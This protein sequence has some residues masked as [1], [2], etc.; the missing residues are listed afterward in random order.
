MRIRTACL[1]AAALCAACA[2]DPDRQT[3]AR[4]HDVEPDMSEVQVEHGLDQAVA[5]YRKFL[6]EAPESSLTPEAMR[7]LADLQIEKEYGLLG[8][9]EGIR[10]M[11]APE[12]SAAPA[13]S[14]TETR[15]APAAKPGHSESEA[16]FERRAAA[17]TSARPSQ[18]G[19]ALDLPG[20]KSAPPGPLEAIA[21]YDQILAKYPNYPHNDEVLYQK[22]RA[23]DELGRTE[24]AIVVMEQMIALYPQSRHMDEVQFRRAEYFFT[25]KKYRDAEAA[26]SAITAMG[27]S[28]EYYE[29]ALYK[30]GWTFYKQ[31]LHVEALHQYVTLLDYKVGTGYDFDTPH[32]EDT[33][34][35]IA[36][37][38]HVV[39]LCFSNLG[40]PESIEQYFGANG[41]KSFEDRIYGHLGEF[42]LEK[43]R[44][45]D[46]A[47][48][49]R[50]FV[51]LNPLH[52]SAP[53][54]SMRVIE[55]YE[56]GGFPKL[57]LESK[58]QFAASYGLDS[59]YWRHFD[60]AASPEVLRYLKT[61]LQ[62]LASHYHARFQDP[63]GDEDREKSFQ[64]AARWYR[65]YLASF[66]KEEES[67]SI[68]YR[69][70]DLLLEHRDF[71][72]AAREYE[73]TA[74]EYPPHERAAAAGYA[75]IYAHRE[76]Q[77]QVS[78][79]EQ[80]TV[81][82]DA[83]AST[84]R[85]VDAFPQH[86]HA[87]A[88]LGAAVD[89]LYELKDY[90]PA[91]ATG[92]KLIERYPDAD[93]AIRRTAWT[94]VA[95]ASFET[96]GYA[97]AEQAY[98]RVLELTPEGDASRQ[99]LSDNL[100]AAIYKQGEQANA[101]ADPRAAAGHFLR[102][103]EAAP[104]S[105][106]RPAAEYDAGA[107]LMKVEDWAKAAEVLEA[108]RQ[109]YPDHELRAD[110]TRQIAF[111]R[112]AQG[113][114]S[115]AGEE[116]ERVSTEAGDSELQREALLEAGDLYEKSGQS[117]RALAAWRSY[118]TRFPDPLETAVE[119]RWKIAERLAASH[120]DAAYRD[121]LGR[122]VA[123]DRAAGGQRTD[124][125]R[126]LAARSA[127]ALSERLYREFG[128][129]ALVQPFEQSLKRK[130]QRM[131]AAL[132]AFG[133]LVDYEVGEVTAA[134]TFYMAELYAD[135]GQ[136]LMKSER[137][138][139]LAG[140]ALREYEDALE[141]EA[142]PFEEK[143]IA[144]HQ[145]NLELMAG[146]I[147][148]PWIEKSLDALARLMPG[149]Y[150]KSEASS[151]YLDSPDGYAYT[152]PAAHAPVEADTVNGM[153]AEAATPA[154]SPAHAEAPESAPPPADA[155]EDAHAN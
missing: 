4:L 16:E 63:E 119:T 25:R 133:D 42:Y 151:G 105:S 5:G 130:K 153:P 110:A 32:D 23:Y 35:R 72:D 37:T 129:V 96:Q 75:A 69:L 14:D 73:R 82:R 33:E 89:D 88:V 84:L 100:A 9:G 98:T 61:N 138:A 53:R 59:E 6:E 11:P 115:R 3:L 116:Y 120:D 40:G 8:D 76:R 51:D 80:D 152:P 2:G 79:A 56:Q 135:F 78:G 34:R 26:Y 65:A 132:A 71:D 29:L 36:D 27:S 131:D 55:I 114:L 46:A 109:H 113:D 137:P 41:H 24:D 90:V 87:A 147:Y 122:I 136:A 17:A 127:L 144:V 102:I 106:I 70:A 145:K 111:A 108:F 118:V 10:E 77:K 123:S 107:A 85:F 148:N 22:S 18:P 86:E 155:A 117:E 52:R 58:K 31:D 121:E 139:N 44:Y 97:Q 95:H 154:P 68:D 49:Y 21:L 101:A 28:S 12:P 126:Y 15:R 74:Y 93:P 64:E 57:V 103:A 91:I 67:A 140:A 45:Q 142:Y 143:A 38:F 13:L 150:A 43:L 99:S 54:F 124:R 104:T 62:D 60:V 39:S 146:G 83:V 19:P 141:E 94:V 20:A 92:Q 66:P 7:R 134:A 30:L 81:R 125:V 149:R 112:R 50:A 48:A 1:S 47:A 128:E